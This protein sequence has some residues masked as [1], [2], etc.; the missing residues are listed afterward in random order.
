MLEVPVGDLSR[1]RVKHSNNNY[2]TNTD[3]G[4]NAGARPK[5]Y[6]GQW[7]WLPA[8]SSVIQ[9][10]IAKVRWELGVLRL[11]NGAMA[12]GYYCLDGARFQTHASQVYPCRLG[13]GSGF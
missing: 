10:G 1:G 9:L 5:F 2:M 7:E 4:L 11:L 3:N 13:K 12:D 8:R 6:S